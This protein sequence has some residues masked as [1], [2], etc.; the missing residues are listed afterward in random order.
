MAEEAMQ[1]VLL[2]HGIPFPV[3][4]LEM[5]EQHRG[6][7]VALGIVTPDVDIPLRASLRGPARPLKPRVQIAGVVQDQVKDHPHA[8]PVGSG[9][10]AMKGRQIAQ[11][12]MDPFEVRDVISAVTQR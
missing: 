1:V 8:L 12:G 5:T 3:G 2:R 7:A 11:I 10:K 9:Q 4:G 6:I